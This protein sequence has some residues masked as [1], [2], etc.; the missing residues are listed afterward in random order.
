MPPPRLPRHLRPCRPLWSARQVRFASDSRSTAGDSSNGAHGKPQEGESQT[1][2][3]E[4][5]ASQLRISTDPTPPPKRTFQRRLAAERR[6]R[7]GGQQLATL[8]QPR[9]HKHLVVAPGDSAK[10]IRAAEIYRQKKEREQKQSATPTQLRIHK[11]ITNVRGVALKRVLA[12]ELHQKNK[13]KAQRA[14]QAYASTQDDGSDDGPKAVA[15]PSPTGP[16]TEDIE[17]LSMAQRMRRA[18]GGSDATLQP[19]VSKVPRPAQFKVHTPDPTSNHAIKRLVSAKSAIVGIMEEKIKLRQKQRQQEPQQKEVQQKLVSQNQQEHQVQ[20]VQ[21]EQQAE[22]E[23]QV[24]QPETNTQSES[25]LRER[26]KKLEEQLAM[27]HAKLAAD[28]TAATA[29]KVEA[30]GGATTDTAEAKAS[31]SMPSGA[32]EAVDARPDKSRTAEEKPAGRTRKGKSAANNGSDKTDKQP[33]TSPK[34]AEVEQSDE[35]TGTPAK[36]AHT[37]LAQQI[38]AQSTSMKS[39]SHPRPSAVS[40]PPSQSTLQTSSASDEI[41]DQSLLDELFPEANSLS[42]PDLSDKR[43]A[44]PKLDL[45]A[46]DTNPKIRLYDMDTRTE[47]EKAIDA[48]RARGEQTTVLQLSNCSTAL[49]EPDFRRLI[50]RGKHIDTWSSAGEFYKIIPG[51]D[52]L[53]LTRLPFYYLLFH[54]A[55]AAL[56]YQKNASRLSKLAT[57]HASF[58]IASA[59]SPPAGFLEDGEDIA[60]VTSSFVLH[61]QGHALDLRTVMQP[62]NPSLRALIDAGGYTPIVPNVDERGNK[63]HRV[64][65]T[66]DGYEP[67]HWDLWQIVLRH[68]H[69]RGILWPWRNDHAS[70]LRRL[71]DTINLKTVSKQKLQDLASSNPRAASSFTTKNNNSDDSHAEDREFEDPTISAFLGPSS[72]SKEAAGDGT[73]AKEVNQ[74]VMNRV[75]NRWIAEFEDEDAARRFAGLW[76]R[77]RLPDAKDRDGKWKEAEEE[78]WV[79]AEYLW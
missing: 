20:Q 17:P 73:S 9:I 36:I 48:F 4:S 24:E 72:S 61:P 25:E 26:L 47:R 43:R 15:P 18:L 32:P 55:A 33:S 6:K 39:S 69:T 11:E 28:N 31:D 22:Q 27:L 41:S 66:I 51:R 58:S 14:Q 50:P 76:H 2:L 56:A 49:T 7:E 59:V 42:P 74:L 60:A 34:Q 71:R 12:A 64:L 63:I 75:Y 57:L 54:S 37:T 19:T 38:Q 79:E 53:S 8:T 40:L 62:Y 3:S 5:H 65:L 77:V 29:S 1:E 23:Q 16:I 46:P 35:N 44:P 10:N 21:K 30:A 67:G 70:A 52:P 13:E 78:R 68:A 45:P